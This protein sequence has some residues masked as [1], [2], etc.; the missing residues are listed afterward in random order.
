M[1]DKLF[2]YLV[3]VV[4]GLYYKK[5]YAISVR[6]L[7]NVYTGICLLA[8]AG[9]V[10][11]LLSECE[12]PWIWAVVSLVGQAAHVLKPLIQ[13][14]K[15]RMALNYIIS[16]T[17][18]LKKD[19]E[20]YWTFYDSDK[21]ANIPDSEVNEQ[22][23]QFKDRAQHYK[24]RFADGLDFPIKQRLLKKANKEAIQYFKYHYNT[25]PG[26]ESTDARQA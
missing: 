10:I 4:L 26:K 7:G 21:A 25:Y 8:S 15:K 9:G 17:E 22:I 1:R 6:R 16:D 5:A 12:I 23:R 2:D 14:D 24:E 18:V 11:S 20:D 13:F 3:E 19:I